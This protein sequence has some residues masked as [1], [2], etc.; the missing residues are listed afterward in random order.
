MRRAVLRRISPSCRSYYAGRELDPSEARASLRGRF[1]Y[2]KEAITILDPWP[3]TRERAD[4]TASERE[5]YRINQEMSPRLAALVKKIENGSAEFRAE[6]FQ[7]PAEK[8]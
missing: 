8:Q 4:R 2:G 7:P 3:A 5:N 1:S 6:P